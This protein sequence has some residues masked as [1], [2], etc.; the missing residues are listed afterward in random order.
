MVLVIYETLISKKNQDSLPAVDFYLIV[1]SK[2]R[3]VKFLMDNTHEHSF[4]KRDNSKISIFVR[5]VA[6]PTF[7]TDKDAQ[8]NASYIIYY[9]REIFFFK[10][11]YLL[12]NFKEKS[13]NVVHFKLFEIMDIKSTIT[14]TLH[15]RWSRTVLFR[16]IARKFYKCRKTFALDFL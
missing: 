14:V 8:R 10:Y 4:Q 5:N 7:V 15:I 2:H 11:Y 9:S 3:F 16:N 12:Q 13:E 1:L 6:L